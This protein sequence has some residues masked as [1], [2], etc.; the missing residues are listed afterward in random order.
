MRLQMKLSRP[1]VLS[2]NEF[3]RIVY[4]DPNIKVTNGYVLG[5]AYNTLIPKLSTIDWKQVDKKHIENVTN[6]NDK[7]ISGVH[8]TLN[9]ESSILNGIEKIQK[10]FLEIF[11]TKRIHKSFVVKLVMFAAILERNNDLPEIDETK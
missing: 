11:N 6:S 1:A 5:A 3:K 2:F 8:T 7:S 4:G 10:D 9:I